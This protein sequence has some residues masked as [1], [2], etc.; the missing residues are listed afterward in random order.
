MCRA[1]FPL[2]DI[3]FNTTC[4]ESFFKLQDTAELGLRGFV[5][6]HSILLQKIVLQKFQIFVAF[7]KLRNSDNLVKNIFQLINPPFVQNFIQTQNFC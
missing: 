7:F 4:D 3:V 6:Y 5:I 1:F 2:Q